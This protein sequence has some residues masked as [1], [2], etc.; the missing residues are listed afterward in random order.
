MSIP[1][2]F[3]ILLPS[4]PAF[5]STLELIIDDDDDDDTLFLIYTELWTIPMS[6]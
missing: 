6:L 4:S 2:H 3:G 5:M 1:K